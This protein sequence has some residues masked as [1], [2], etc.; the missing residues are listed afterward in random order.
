M[1]LLNVIALLTL[2]ILNYFL[3]YTVIVMLG[4]GLE[5]A[6]YIVF[7]TNKENKGL[8]DMISGVKTI[9]L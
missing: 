2:N 5:L 1:V 8:N 4:F 6:S 9:N 7:F 3:A